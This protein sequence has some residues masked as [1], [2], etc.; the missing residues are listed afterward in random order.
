MTFVLAFFAVSLMG[1]TV[2]LIAWA[3]GLPRMHALE[4]IGKSSNYGM[5]GA[6]GEERLAAPSCSALE[7]VA[8]RLGDIAMRYLGA[9]EEGLKKELV[10]AGMYRASPAAFVGYFACWQHS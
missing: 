10:A 3:I 2:A 7:G 1:V 9:G 8:R 6:P 5:L 4:R